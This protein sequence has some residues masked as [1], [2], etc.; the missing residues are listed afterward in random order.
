[1][2]VHLRAF[3]VVATLAS[4]TAC[5]TPPAATPQLTD[6]APATTVPPSEMGAPDSASPAAL[7]TTV[8]PDPVDRR[9]EIEALTKPLWF[10]WYDAV[11]AGDVDALG[12]TVARS[13]IHADGITA[14]STAALDFTAE[15]RMEDYDFTVSEVLRDDADCIV[16]AIREDPTAFLGGA[17][18][19]DRIGVF[20]HHEDG[21]YLA[22]S[23]ARDAP[24]FAWADDC[25]L[26]VRDFA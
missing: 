20:W 21:W 17:I 10:G 6:P 7:T 25:T 19:A 12:R 22:T 11:A 9:L 18:V 4:A 24:E 14:I 2:F 8:E 16:V 13:R 26:M 1:M 5:A 15:P 23:W 3:L